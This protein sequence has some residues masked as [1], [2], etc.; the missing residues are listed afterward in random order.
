MNCPNCN[1]HIDKHVASRC[2]DAWVAVDVM[3]HSDIRKRE[4][5][6]GGY[7]SWRYCLYTGDCHESYGVNC[8]FST[9]I[10]A[11][12]VVHQKACSLLFSK[13]REYLRQLCYSVSARVLNKDASFS[14]LARIKWPDVMVFLEPVDFCRA[15]IITFLKSE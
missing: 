7:D 5:V 10:A 1:V 9:S 11:A 12:W 8:F 14:T 6:V 13:R 3:G 15:A 4:Q 2:F